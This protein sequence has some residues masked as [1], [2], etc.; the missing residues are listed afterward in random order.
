[1][2]QSAASVGPLQIQQGMDSPA[3]V[4]QDVVHDVR[5]GIILR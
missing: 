5:V 3:R 1:M 4:A 2:R